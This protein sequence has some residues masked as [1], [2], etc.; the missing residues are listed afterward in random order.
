MFVDKPDKLFIDPEPRLNN[1]KLTVKE[2]ETI[3]PYNCSADCNPPCKI[4]WE[5]KD[6]AGT[7]GHILTVPRVN[8]SIS[9]LRCLAIYMGK[10]DDNKKISLDVQC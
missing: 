6:T 9:F 5:Y 1:G 7:G 8:R 4:T 2:G 10:K 3:G